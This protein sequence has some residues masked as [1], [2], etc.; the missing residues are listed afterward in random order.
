MSKEKRAHNKRCAVLRNERD[1]L[2]ARIMGAAN[3][4]AREHYT[5]QLAEVERQ[6]QRMN[7]P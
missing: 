3:T 4:I 6:I 1:R 5:K 7:C 2:K